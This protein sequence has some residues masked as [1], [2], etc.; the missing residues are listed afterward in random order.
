[1]YKNIQCKKVWQ[2]GTIVCLLVKGSL[3]IIYH[4]HHAAQTVKV[5]LKTGEFLHGRPVITGLNDV[6]GFKYFLC[7]ISPNVVHFHNYQE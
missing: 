2:Y 3:W 4:N 6:L 1:M 7:N 5:C